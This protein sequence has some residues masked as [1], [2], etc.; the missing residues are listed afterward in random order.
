MLNN[1]GNKNRQRRN[2]RYN[3][4]IITTSRIPRNLRGSYPFPESQ[5]VKLTALFNYAQQGAALFV[6]RDF[7]LNS[8][9]QFDITGGTTHDF[10]G[11]NQLGNIYDSYHVTACKVNYQLHG[12]ETG[13]AVSFGLIFRDTQP[14]TLITTFQK[15]VNA[16]EVAPTTGPTMVGQATGMDIFRSRDF[17]LP[18]SSILGNPSGYMGD[19]DYTSSFGAFNP[20]QALWMSAVAYSNGGANL[21]NG[22]VVTLKVELTVRCYSIKVL[23]E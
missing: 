12:N 19:V 20:T 8:L 21:T 11:D 14:S 13:Q 22:I 15:A 5:I 2:R 1:R 17:Y 9:Y 18:L 23:E 6:V 3:N 4:N 16:L 7:R 10:S